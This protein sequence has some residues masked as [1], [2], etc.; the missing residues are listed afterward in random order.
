MKQRTF[1]R[2]RL[3]V[4]TRAIESDVE[5]KKYDGAVVL[6]ARNGEV[7]LREAGGFSDREKDVALTQEHVFPVFSV[8]K[9]ITAT[10]VLQNVEKGDISL[11]MPVCEV[12]P[13]FGVKSKQRITITHLLTHTGGMT[14]DFPA[15]TF[16]DQGR[17]DNVVRWACQTALLKP[18]GEAVCYRPLATHAVLAEIVRRVDGARRSFREIVAEEVFEPLGMK[19][20]WMGGRADLLERYVSVVAR[21]NRPG[22]FDIE[23]VAGLASHIILNPEVKAEIPAAGIMSAVDDIFRFA[24][25]WECFNA[26]RLLW[27]CRMLLFQN[28]TWQV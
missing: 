23:G 21:D 1:N 15:I 9:P 3:K 20:S 26:S 24:I 27:D 19:D 10:T 6:V 8:S 5:D 28:E 17:L 16:E 25:P 14:S 7:A 11:K 2:E 4:L 12:I 22:L 13:E 18:Q